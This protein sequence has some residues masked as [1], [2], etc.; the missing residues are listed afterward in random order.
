MFGNSYHTIPHSSNMNAV[1]SFGAHYPP[2]GK[3]VD[4]LKLEIIKKL[5]V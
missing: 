1:Y 4:F 5:C 2:H 3:L